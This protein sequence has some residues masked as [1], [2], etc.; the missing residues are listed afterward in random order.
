ML[1]P[2]AL[3][4]DKMHCGTLY[5]LSISAHVYTPLSH[6]VHERVLWQQRQMSYDGNCALSV[7]EVRDRG[8]PN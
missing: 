7:D 2:S 3:L 6:S 5:S 4:A 1:H 8:S